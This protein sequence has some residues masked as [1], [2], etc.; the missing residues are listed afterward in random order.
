MTMMSKYL[1]MQH[2][3]AYIMNWKNK[4]QKKH[5]MSPLY[6]SIKGE[7]MMLSL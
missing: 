5:D 1:F 6:T 2:K 3:I 7:M 4:A